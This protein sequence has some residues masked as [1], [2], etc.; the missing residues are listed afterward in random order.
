MVQAADDAANAKWYNVTELPQLGFDHKLIVRECFE[1]VAKLPEAIEGG[2]TEQLHQAV[3]N[4]AGD[5]R[6]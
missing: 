3:T 4:L 2:M 5:W 1:H 6:H